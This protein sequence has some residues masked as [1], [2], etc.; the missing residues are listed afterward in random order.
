MTT[1]YY[2]RH[3]DSFRT[4]FVA[5]AVVVAMVSGVALATLARAD[6]PSD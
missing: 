3:K 1:G 6:H 4:F 2:Q 5:L